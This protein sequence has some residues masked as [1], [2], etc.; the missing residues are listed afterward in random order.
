MV[1]EL[2]EGEEVKP[3]VFVNIFKISPN[4]KV[5]RYEGQLGM[6][7][8]YRYIGNIDILIYLYRYRGL[9]LLQKNNV[10]T[11]KIII[12]RMSV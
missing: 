4:I 9:S 8:I 5:I 7:T 11:A 10:T 1:A 12:S 6:A 3:P 2:L